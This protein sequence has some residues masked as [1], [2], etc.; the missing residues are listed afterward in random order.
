MDGMK[1]SPKGHFTC[2][3]IYF[4]GLFFSSCFFFLVFIVFSSMPPFSF[5]FLFFSFF[6]CHPWT[7]FFSRNSPYPSNLLSTTQPIYLAHS[8]HHPFSFP[9]I[10]RTWKP[11]KPWLI[12]FKVCTSRGWGEELVELNMRRGNN[13]KSGSLKTIKRSRTLKESVFF[14]T[15]F[16]SLLL[17]LELGWLSS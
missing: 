6:S 3:Y 10:T 7:H 9:S 5:F 11:Q 12:G 4:W 8:T 14:P 16:L 15:F 2:Q 17:P 13:S 1:L